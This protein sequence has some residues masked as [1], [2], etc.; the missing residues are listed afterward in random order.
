M[1]QE[2]LVIFLGLFFKNTSDVFGEQKSGLGQVRGLL[3][4][5]GSGINI[6]GQGKAM[7]YQLPP[8]TQW[9]KDWVKI[10]FLVFLKN[11]MLKQL[12]ILPK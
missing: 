11:I 12:R 10:G 5:F 7:S 6:S 9:E 3:F 2:D 1:D 4:G 8:F